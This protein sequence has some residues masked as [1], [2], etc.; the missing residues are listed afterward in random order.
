VPWEPPTIHFRYGTSSV[1]KV[2]RGEKLATR[3]PYTDTNVF[4][5]EKLVG[6][7][8]RLYEGGKHAYAVVT[9]VYVQRLGDVS[10]EDARKEGFPSLEE[11][12]RVWREI[13][14]S[15]NPEQRVVVIEF[16]P[17]GCWRFKPSR[18]KIAIEGVEAP[19]CGYPEEEGELGRGCAFCWLSPV[20]W[21]GNCKNL[22][23]VGSKRLC[24]AMGMEVEIPRLRVKL[25]T[26]RKCEFYSRNVPRVVEE[27]F[28]KLRK[29]GIS[30]IS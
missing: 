12:K 29:R 18:K 3:R 7:I 11:F 21:C 5:F 25:G 2:L 19:L 15:F 9:N 10:D 1:E 24:T 26:K 4:Y 6:K 30:R 14:G 22:R 20:E 16:V 17:Y 23:V 27:G 8:V 28:R 13:Y